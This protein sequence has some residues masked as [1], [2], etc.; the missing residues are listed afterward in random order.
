M[1]INGRTSQSPLTTR[2][3]ATGRL[4]LRRGT[5]HFS[6]VVDK[7]TPYF[8]TVQFLDENQNILEELEMQPTPYEANNGRICGTWTRV[9][10]QYR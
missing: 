7:N 4:F 1:L 9:P 8:T 3:L 5:L 2:R 10:R 6:F